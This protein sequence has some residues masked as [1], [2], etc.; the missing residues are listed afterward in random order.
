[1]ILWMSDPSSPLREPIST[2]YLWRYHQ[3]H[4]KMYTTRIRNEAYN[5]KG[6]KI[7]QIILVFPAN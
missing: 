1:M 5:A 2:A 4:G 7:C 6:V 3:G